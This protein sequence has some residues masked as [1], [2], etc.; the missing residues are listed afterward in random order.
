MFEWRNIYRGIFIG[1]SDLI[2]GVSGGTI[3]VIFGFYEQLIAS[4]S[5]FF[6]REWKK[7]LGFLIP[8][9]FGVGFSMFLLSKVIG[10]LLAKHP[11]PTYFFFLGLIVGVLP[12]L[13]KEAEGGRSFKL[14]HYILLLLAAI[15]IAYTVFLKP[16]ADNS[17]IE[18][19]SSSTV[20]LFFFAGWLGSMAMILPGISGSF[21]LLLLG[22]Y[23]TAIDALSTFNIPVISI[24]GA[25]VVVGFITST[26]FIH[27]LLTQFS[28]FMYA[29]IIGMV[30]GSL[31]VVYPSSLHGSVGTIS[32]SIVTMILGFIAAHYLGKQKLGAGR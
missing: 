23:P 25:G 4:I 24:I 16:G 15:T 11:Q 19:T 2:P 27:F 14:T 21:V 18:L 5:G 30:V 32:L 31:A 28:S 29:I 17:I 3:A 12:F 13:W 10:W 22:V 1:V 9:A 26:K 8:L 6:S 7:Y 20:F